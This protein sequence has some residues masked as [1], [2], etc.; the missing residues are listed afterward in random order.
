MIDIIKLTGLMILTVR[1]SARESLNLRIRS[2]I[3]S[4]KVNRIKETAISRKGTCTDEPSGRK[5]PDNNHNHNG[6]IP[7]ECAITYSINKVQSLMFPVEQGKVKTSHSWFS[8]ICLVF[9]LCFVNQ[10][11]LFK[12]YVLQ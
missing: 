5:Y 6:I 1:N 11:K 9:Q 10:I 3:P 7:A 2:P 12:F 8:K 4:G